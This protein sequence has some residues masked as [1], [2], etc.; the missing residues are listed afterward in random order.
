MTLT[1]L[2]QIFLDIVSFKFLFFFF[3]SLPLKQESW[4]PWKRVSCHPSYSSCISGL[5]TS[6]RGL[7]QGYLGLPVLPGNSQLPVLT[8]EGT[9]ISLYFMQTTDRNPVGCCRLVRALGKM[10]CMLIIYK[11][12]N[13]LGLMGSLVDGNARSHH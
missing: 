7:F 8:V 9:W 6:Y 11:V 4:D 3:F 12:M 2:L 5:C 13:K 1:A 10:C